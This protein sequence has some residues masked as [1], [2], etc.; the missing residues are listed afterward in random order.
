MVDPDT[1][2]RDSVR[3]MV[4]EDEPKLAE[5][6]ARALAG[7]GYDVDVVNRGDDAL[8]RLMAPQAPWAIVILDRM[9]PG[10]D[11]LEVCRLLRAAGNSTPVLMLT[12]LGSVDDRIDGLDGGANDYLP[13]PFA[14]KELYA[15][16]RVLLRAEAITANAAV[17]AGAMLNVGDLSLD[18]ERLAAFRGDERIE[19]RPKE[20]AI[21]A[22]LMERADRVVPR[23]V[24]HEAAWG[25]VDAPSAN[26][27][28]VHIG[29]IR[30][31]VDKPF[32][33]VSIETIRG[34][35]YRIR[36]ETP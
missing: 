15:R 7:Q 2:A 26:D 20:A 10:I 11:G 34:A 27:L 16:I 1:T 9:L 28:D 36:S 24:I 22:C 13:K 30:N 31:K 33:R 18:V 32:D 29:R 35:G 6:V 21:L 12:A 19:L 8:R 14:L 4:V 23:W 3:V 25:D 17:E 5:I